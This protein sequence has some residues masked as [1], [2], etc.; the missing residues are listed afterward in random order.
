M[1]KILLYNFRKKEGILLRS[2]SD[3]VSLVDYIRLKRAIEKLGQKPTQ[4][5]SKFDNQPVTYEDMYDLFIMM[6]KDQEVQAKYWHGVEKRLGKII[7]GLMNQLLEN[8][9]ITEEQI[10]ALVPST[11]KQKGDHND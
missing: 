2:D 3:W 8:G 1:K 5:V 4:N 7:S 9:I 10:K 11:K 6:T